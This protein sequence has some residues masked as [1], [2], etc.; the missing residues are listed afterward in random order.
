MPPKFI[1]RQLSCP[2]GFL[3][4]IIR[5]R[6]NSHNADLNA[7]VI[8]LLDVRSTD[9]VLEIGFGGGLN[10]PIL[11]SSAASFT[12]LDLSVDSVRHAQKKFSKDVAERRA[13]FCTGDV[14]DL[15]FP[16]ESFD[17]VCTANTIYFWNSLEAGFTEIHRVLSPGGTLVVGFMPKEFMDK[18]GMPS[19]IFTLRTPE[20][21]RS[22]LS[23]AGFSEISTER[24]GSNGRWVAIVATR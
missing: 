13:S 18:E 22:A 8:K 1:A 17:K 10:L 21:V 9:R 24:L 11:V 23:S 5:R 4:R 20:E 2:S 19:D 6:M 16:S 14:K 15:P 7:F 12:G 3:G